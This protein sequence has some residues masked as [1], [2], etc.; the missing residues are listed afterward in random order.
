VPPVKA[1]FRL[2]CSFGLT[3][4]VCQ[5]GGRGAQGARKRRYYAAAEAAADANNA[6]IT[7][8]YSLL[9]VRW[10]RSEERSGCQGNQTRAQ[11]DAK[12]QHQALNSRCTR[13]FAANSARFII[14][15]NMYCRWRFRCCKCSGL[16]RRRGGRAA[17][18]RRSDD[19]ICLG[20]TCAL[21]DQ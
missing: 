10:R 6:G 20:V 15:A 12:L 8:A 4:V 18:I 5:A 13:T 7:I 16:M 3:R 17:V 1:R 14:R 11:R 21:R 19:G 9:S 2:L